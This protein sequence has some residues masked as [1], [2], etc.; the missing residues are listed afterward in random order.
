VPQL[1]F[2]FH[3]SQNYAGTDAVDRLRG[4]MWGIVNPIGTDGVR[5]MIEKPIGFADTNGII[6]QG[7][8]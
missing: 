1:L 6:R 5:S 2:Y 7:S 8:I 3:S 4:G